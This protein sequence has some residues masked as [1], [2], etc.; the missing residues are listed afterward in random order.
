MPNHT[1]EGAVQNINLLDAAINICR[2]EMSANT[3]YLI[4]FQLLLDAAVDVFRGEMNASTLYLT[5][6]ILLLYSYVF[7]NLL[8]FNSFS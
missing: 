2:G 7:L 6:F 3:L 5:S 8:F 4:S 1:E